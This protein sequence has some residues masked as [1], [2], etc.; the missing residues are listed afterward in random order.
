MIRQM[1]SKV[2]QHFDDEHYAPGTVGYEMKREAEAY[3]KTEA[4]RRR[5]EKLTKL[6]LIPPGLR[7]YF[8]S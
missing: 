5:L 2:R 7:S 6:G 1:I 4:K 3:K 8:E